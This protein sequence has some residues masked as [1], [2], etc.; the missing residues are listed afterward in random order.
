MA[1][2]KG[3]YKAKVPSIGPGSVVQC[4]CL[5]IFKFEREKSLSIDSEEK[6]CRSMEQEEEVRNGSLY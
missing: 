1:L 5:Q 2:V 6:R 4:T 3:T